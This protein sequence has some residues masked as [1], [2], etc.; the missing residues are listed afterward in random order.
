MSG[1]DLHH[2]RWISPQALDAN[3][4]SALL[5]VAT[6]GVPGWIVV[7]KSKDKHQNEKGNN[8]VDYNF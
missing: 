3:E 5:H 4:R 1:L 2:G 8:N 6:V 7:Q